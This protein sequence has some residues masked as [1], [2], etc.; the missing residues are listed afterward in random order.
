MYDA[1]LEMRQQHTRNIDSL[2]EF[3]AFFTPKNAEKPEI[4]GG[5]AMCHWVED[6]AVKPVL[7]KL[8]VTHRCI[9]LDAQPEAGT[10]I[11]TGKPSQ[12]RVVFAKAY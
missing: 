12:Q 7:E 11:F 5:F 6:P 8:K 3:E 9:P 2:E 4:H 10:C 1:A